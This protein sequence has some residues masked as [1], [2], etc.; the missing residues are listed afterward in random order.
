[1]R[2]DESAGLRIS[3]NCYYDS[4]SL[5]FVILYSTYLQCCA[6]VLTIHLQNKDFTGPIISSP[7]AN[8][9]KINHNIHNFCV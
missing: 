2:A 9:T 6:T 1:M 8:A 4:A 5:R 7:A 3:M